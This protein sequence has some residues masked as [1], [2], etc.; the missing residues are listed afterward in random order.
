VNKGASTSEVT[1]QFIQEVIRPKYIIAMHIPTKDIE[2]ESKQ[3]L[4]FYPNGLVFMKPL[5]KKTLT[6]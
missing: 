3:F 2:I 5:E 4:S 6:K 1:K